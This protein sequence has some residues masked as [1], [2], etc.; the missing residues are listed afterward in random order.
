MQQGVE[1]QEG[2][3]TKNFIMHVVIPQRNSL[4]NK[5]EGDDILKQPIIF[6]GW[7]N[8]PQYLHVA[9]TRHL[10]EQ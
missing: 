10:R 1:G 7:K 8:L 2:V 6:Y 5:N 9:R 3:P 4:G